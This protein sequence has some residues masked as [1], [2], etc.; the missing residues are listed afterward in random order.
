MSEFQW[1]RVLCSSFRFGGAW[2]HRRTDVGIW[3]RVSFGLRVRFRCAYRV[4]EAHSSGVVHSEMV[5]SWSV[6]IIKVDL[7]MGQS[8]YHRIA[9]QFYR[10][11]IGGTGG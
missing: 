6:T 2:A 7:V 10:A 3:S 11:R 9:K 4:V 5:P 8:G 1:D